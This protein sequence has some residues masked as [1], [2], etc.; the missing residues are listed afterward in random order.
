MREQD[1]YADARDGSA[2]PL[3]GV[4]VVDVTKVWSGPL[5]TCVLADLGADVIS[6]E[7]AGRPDGEVPPEIP[8]TGLSWFRQTVRRNKRSIALDLRGT[9][10]RATF[11]RLVATAD[12]VVENYKPGTLDG[13]GAGYL[14][15]REVAPAIVFVSI[16]GWGQ[17]GPNVHLPAYD[18]VIQAASGWMAQN[19]PPGGPPA[20]APTFL[21]DELAGL[22]AV[23]GALAALAYRDR[24]GEG[25]HV[26]V[27]MMDSIL[28]SS[29][30][31]PTL[32]ATGAPP[33]R[34]GNETDFVVPSN[35][36]P[37]RDGHLYLTV[38]LS[39]HWRALAQV[40]GRPELATAEGYRSNSERLANR[41]AINQIVSQWCRGR[42]A[43]AA[44]AELSASGIV[45][46]PV[47]TF[48]Q[49][50]ADPH[51]TARGT[52]Q[53]TVLSN[54]RTAPLAGPPVKFSRT[55]ARI[56]RGA[57]Q[58]GADT[59]EILAELGIQPA[60]SKVG[61]RAAMPSVT[62]G[63]HTGAAD[64]RM[65]TAGQAAART[66]MG[67]EV[68]EQHRALVT[69]ASRGIGHAIAL[70]LA[71]DGHAVAG[72]FSTA[73]DAAKQAEADVAELGVP[74]FFAVCDVSDPAAVEAF[75]RAAEERLG[76]LD[77]LVNN[78]GITRDSPLVLGK[79]DDWADVLAT[80][81]TGTR[82]FC[83][84]L[85]FRFMKNR[86]GAMVNLSS[87]AG[88]QG[89]A[90]QTAY[91]ASKAGIIGFSK[92]LAREVAGYGIRVNVVA[93]GFIETD[94]TKALSD[95]LRDTALSRI[96]LGRF[97]RPEDV[98]ELVAF[99]LSERAAYITGQVFQVDGGIAL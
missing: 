40:I 71:Q 96:P 62:S 56:R 18:P 50:V 42:T 74:C 11:L 21:A 63:Q 77:L 26:D 34:M 37:C 29:S 9:E 75:V 98:A 13:W 36:Y 72:C 88:L 7:L 57:P 32:A 54:G 92:S 8:G 30:G 69:G 91:A 68:A 14:A 76:P 5:A 59:A 93:P 70:R 87:V 10:D 39:K 99:L 38:A 3:D 80:N 66:Q 31:L 82:N 15:C 12:L 55:P 28:F 86:G 2:G 61:S 48:A 35:V 90:G 33:P 6:V 17:Y 49:A 4:R 46:A 81:L 47:R 83:S 22:H 60:T 27:S 94:M 89:N 51:V 44:A 1:F 53:Q 45:A 95:K 24:T 65:H 23:T 16:S 97:G 58:P 52:L 79:Y 43:A 73:S 67:A 64:G 41:D 25:Q 19:G 85:A 84:S 78:A 20:R